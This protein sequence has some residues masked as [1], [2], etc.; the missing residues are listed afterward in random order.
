[1]RDDRLSFAGRIFD[2]EEKDVSVYLR[3]VVLGV[4]DRNYDRLG[5]E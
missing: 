4:F 2:D 5:P 1:M 3:R